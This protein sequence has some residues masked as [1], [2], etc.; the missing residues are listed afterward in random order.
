MAARIRTGVVGLGYFGSFHANHYARHPGAELVAIAD[1]NAARAATAEEVYFAS[2]HRDHRDLIGMV[3]A[4][5]IT[6]PTAQHYAIA[7]DFIEAGVH[8]L[9]EKPL[10]ENAARADDLARR[11]DRAG[12]VLNV[13]H[14]ERFSPT[15]RA[16]RAAVG[17]P[18]L[19]EC[20]RHAPWKARATDVDVV[21]DLMI[22]D[23]DLALDLAGSPVVEVAASGVAM[24]GLGLDAV[25]ARLG[26]ANGAAAHI[27][28]SRVAPLASRIIR[29]HEPR[30]AFAADLSARTL[31]MFTVDR[32]ETTALAVPQED[33]L[34][35][36][37]D[38]FLRSVAGEAGGGVDGRA[39][40]TAL[41]IAEAI[42][43][44]ALPAPAAVATALA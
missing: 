34:G 9:V 25:V 10:C 22:H 27:S 13:G 17:A 33:A 6:A 19:I 35:M 36:E 14:V 44:A 29:V 21:L 26:F 20:R 23:I 39:A 7:C 24:M 16:L 11:A 4:V 38:I 41:D 28:A 3:D 12:V 32:A 1:P 42:R 5:S 30:R 43:H 2:F 8:V 15:Y 18:V 37:I 40:R 31:T